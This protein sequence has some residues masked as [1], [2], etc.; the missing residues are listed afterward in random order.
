[1]KSN[2]SAS[3]KILFLAVQYTSAIVGPLVKFAQHVRISG[4]ARSP[5][6]RSLVEANIQGEGPPQER[7]SPRST[8]CGATQRQRPSTE[9][10]SCLVGHSRSCTPP[11]HVLIRIC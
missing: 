1:M 6:P 8:L 10:S 2:A 9:L 7:L 5:R 11:L 3:E 4:G